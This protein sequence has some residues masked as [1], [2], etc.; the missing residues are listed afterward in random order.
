M[1]SEVELF[2]DSV[3]AKHPD[4]FH[5]KRVLEVGSL[6]INGSIRSKFTE[7]TYLGLDIGKGPGVDL[8]CSIHRFF[9]PTRFDV[10]IST[11]MLEHDQYWMQSL[12]SMYDNLTQGGLMVLTCA[13]P[14]R[15]EHGTTRTTPTDSPFTNDYYRNISIE[16]F[17]S[18]LDEQ[19]FE[20]SHIEYKRANTDLCFYGIK[21]V[22][23]DDPT[24]L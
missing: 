13:G 24:K 12:K 8:I 14:A 4:Y 11:E 22:L 9:V 18:T 2:I 5:D 7:C 23:N 6:D 10:V 1:H 15:Q 16:D 19:M 3:K 20:V 17:R 21:P